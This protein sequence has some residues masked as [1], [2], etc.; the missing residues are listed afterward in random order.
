MAYDSSTVFFLL[1]LYFRKVSISCSLLFSI[2]EKGGETVLKDVG[3]VIN[4][5]LKGKASILK[6]PS[7]IIL[8]VKI[9]RLHRSVTKLCPLRLNNLTIC[10]P[11]K[12]NVTRP[13]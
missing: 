13:L 9:I 8:D 6:L 2:Y 5:C 7:R 4:I 11:I 12:Q 1:L 3:T 10:C